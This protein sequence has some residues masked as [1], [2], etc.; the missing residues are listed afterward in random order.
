MIAI[1]GGLFLAAALVAVQSFGAPGKTLP[2]IDT[3]ALP[4]DAAAA[5]AEAYAAAERQPDDPARVGRLAMVL[6]AWEE[7]DPAAATY[8]LAQTLAP[9]DDR[10]WH[11]AGLLETRRGRHEH[12]L[13]LFERAAALAP[14]DRAVRLRVAEATLET[15]DLQGSE[16]LF[17]ELARHAPTM[18]AAA[19]GLGRVAMARGEPETALQHFDKAVAAFPEFSAAHYGRALAHRRLGRTAE[20]A[21]ALQRQQQCLSCWPATGDPVAESLAQVREDPGAVLQRGIALA[22]DGQDRLSIEAH[23]RALA[24]DADLGQARVNLITLYGRAGDWARAAAAYQE[25]LRRETHIAEAHANY[26]QVLLAER[27]AAE[28]VP[29]F[30]QALAANPAD[31]QAWNGL[32]LALETTGDTAAASA[33]YRQAVVHAPAFRSARFNYARTLVAAGQ[34]DEAIVELEKIRVPEDD[35]APRYLFALSA[36]LVRA[37]NVQRGRV[38]A[39][40]ALELARRYGQSDLAATIERDLAM[41][42][43]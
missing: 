34:L 27:R 28:A 17:A 16:R 23:E 21:E 5:I 14:D 6:H 29:V 43:N 25:A 8:R 1:A 2:A 9:R 40:A 13:P 35:E 3:A 31:G 4:A 41:L 38:E 22:R 36:A 32:G 7:W 11:L 37:G 12:A 33:A 42:N 26:G 19:Y 10:W 15:G 18:A 20:A 30:R 39:L 24:L